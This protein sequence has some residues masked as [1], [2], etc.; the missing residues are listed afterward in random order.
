MPSV[1]QRKLF[2][3]ELSG[4]L[5]IRYGILDARALA[6]NPGLG[7]LRHPQILFLTQ[8]SSEDSSRH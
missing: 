8:N 7:A 6:D 4:F 2:Q 5:E 3:V 1:R